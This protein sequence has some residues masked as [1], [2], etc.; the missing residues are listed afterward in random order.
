MT[1]YD[2]FISARESAPGDFLALVELVDQEAVEGG[3]VLEQP[4]E[5]LAPHQRDLGLA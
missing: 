4:E 2:L 5:G 1:R 3:G